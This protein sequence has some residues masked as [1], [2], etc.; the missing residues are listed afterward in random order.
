LV[1]PRYT[2]DPSTIEDPVI[3]EWLQRQLERISDYWPED[4]EAR[5]A[6]LEGTWPYLGGTWPVVDVSS[7]NML[8]VNT[9]ATYE[10][11]AF[12][13]HSWG[14]AGEVLYY[15]SGSDSWLFGTQTHPEIYHIGTAKDGSN[16][17]LGADGEGTVYLNR[18]SGLSAW[19]TR[20]N[21]GGVF[22]SRSDGHIH[23]QD[24]AWYLFGKKNSTQR[25]PLLWKSIDDGL[26]WDQI[27]SFQSDALEADTFNCFWARD[28]NYWVCVTVWRESATSTGT[29]LPCFW[30][31]TDQGQSW[32]RSTMDDDIFDSRF[33]AQ[34][35][36]IRVNGVITY[37]EFHNK[38]VF[39][40]RYSSGLGIHYILVRDG[41]EVSGSNWTLTG[42]GSTP[43]QAES[44]NEW[45][46]IQDEGN[47]LRSNDGGQSWVGGLAGSV[48]QLQRD[49]LIAA[50]TY[51]LVCC[52]QYDV[53]RHSADANDT[54]DI[55]S[56]N[57]FGSS[58]RS[59]YIADNRYE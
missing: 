1:K 27:Y 38:W 8:T 24:G 34:P 46:Y 21:F 36:R 35:V 53:V 55:V 2:P 4:L 23:W 39:A 40:G 41:P 32:T 12:G 52:T 50:P 44:L 20:G 57:D 31:S 54:W 25:I 59:G 51:G 47:V 16:Y 37:N 56:T 6:A 42:A 17:I 5:L 29:G 30:I 9:Q 49:C 15:D 3:R 13:F 10:L 19:E 58:F 7:V 28:K 43:Y 11:G 45:V 26:T 22:N 18:N 14:I 48:G 33:P